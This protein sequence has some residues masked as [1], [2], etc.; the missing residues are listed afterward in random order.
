MG[1]STAASLAHLVSGESPRGPSRGPLQPSVVT[2]HLHRRLADLAVTGALSMLRLCRPEARTSSRK[3]TRR[4][5]VTDRTQAVPERDNGAAWPEPQHSRE[6]D[7]FARGQ[8]RFSP[9][10][11]TWS[12]TPHQERALSTA[13]CGSETKRKARRGLVGDTPSRR[14]ALR[15]QKPGSG[16]ER[17]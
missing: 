2:P 15:T 9:Q 10:Q 1:P 17:A 16:Q 12:P 7:R 5:E 4:L 13:G 8:P 3:L 14:N 6:G 11:P